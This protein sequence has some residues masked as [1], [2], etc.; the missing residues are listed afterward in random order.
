MPGKMQDIPWKQE[1][2][3]NMIKL[4]SLKEI[5]GAESPH[6]KQ[7]DRALKARSDALNYINNIEEL[8][9]FIGGRVEK[10]GLHE[11]WSVSKE[12]FP[13]VTVHFMFNKADD[14]FPANLKVLFS[15]DRL[16]LL[17][18]EDLAGITIAY[19]THMLRYIRTANPDVKLPEV[20][21]RV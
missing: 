9:G 2:Q 1:P 16:K 17:S 12:I 19:V 14:E 13:G 5:E 18:G 7:V 21:Y 11:D 3:N 8:A 6:Q 10:L 20:C 4:V 15:G